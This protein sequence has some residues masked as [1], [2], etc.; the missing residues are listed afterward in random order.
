MQLLFMDETASEPVKGLSRIVA[1]TGVVL[2]VTRYAQARSRFYQSFR[3]RRTEGGL[4]V[5][6]AP[7]EL[8]G[9]KLLPDATDDEKI[10]ALNR[11]ADVVLEYE[12]GIYRFGYVDHKNLKRFFNSDDVAYALSWAD[13]VSAVQPELRD[14]PLIPVADTGNPQLAEHMSR[15][16]RNIDV[17]REAGF[18]GSLSINAT[19]NIIG[20]VFFG[21]SKYSVFVQVADIV[22]YLLLQ[23]DM[24]RVGWPIS[25]FKERVLVVADRLVSAIRA[26][27]IAQ[28]QMQGSTMV[29]QDL[30]PP[31]K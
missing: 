3:G 17:L 23:R 25:Q 8:H 14:G 19:E 28:A 22:S 26:E 30:R 13:L 21:D 27:R 20:E 18:G 5:D 4:T 31:P 1:V 10:A 16:I 6:L 7:I 24:R 11:V 12:L 29:L 9:R 15:F 2:P